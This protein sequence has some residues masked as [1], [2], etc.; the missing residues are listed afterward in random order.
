MQRVMFPSFISWLAPLSHTKQYHGLCSLSACCIFLSRSHLQK[1]N[2]P[3]YPLFFHCIPDLTLWLILPS[4][5]NGIK[6]F[7][8]YLFL[9]NKYRTP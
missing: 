4:P 1:H 9:C 5:L 3:D 8:Y 2:S 7:L 6:H